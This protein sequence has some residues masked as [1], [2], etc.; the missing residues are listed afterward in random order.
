MC[1]PQY[2][3]NHASH[4]WTCLGKPTAHHQDTPASRSSSVTYHETMPLPLLLLFAGRVITP[5]E[6]LQPYRTLLRPMLIGIPSRHRLLMQ[7]V[8]IFRHRH[9]PLIL[10]VL[11][12]RT[13][14]RP[15]SQSCPPPPRPVPPVASP[16]FQ[17]PNLQTMKDPR[18]SV[19][20]PGV[21]NRT[22]PF[23][24]PCPAHRQ[25]GSLHVLPAT[26]RLP[27][28][29]Q[30]SPPVTVFFVQTPAGENQANPL[31]LH[32]CSPVNRR[33]SKRTWFF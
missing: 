20:I 2:I 25:P 5:H 30:A 24:H 23:L 7:G 6:P 4:L 28:L 13:R 22:R 21:T 12:L 11:I 16:N 17:N 15:S 31:V 3:G 19:I 10:G 27:R 33:N 9:R 32:E 18:A 29:R 8:L 14:C 1:R 26:R